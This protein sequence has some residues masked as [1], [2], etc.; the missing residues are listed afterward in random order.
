MSTILAYTS[1][2]IGH[3]YPLTP[4]LLELQR[5]G[6]DVH[7]CTLE[8]RVPLMQSL[9]FTARPIDPRI[10]ALQLK[11]YTASGPRQALAL[12]GDVFATRGKLEAPD[13]TA[14]I[15][16]VRPDTV[17]VDVNSWGA[18]FAAEAWGGPWVSFAP[19][20]PALHSKGTPPFGPGLAP[21][22]G[23]LGSLRDAV[24]GR[25]VLGA[26]ERGMMPRLNQLRG[27]LSLP[28]VTSDEFLR[29]APLMLVA[30]A[31]PFEYATTEWGPDVIMVGASAWEPFQD[32]PAWLGGIVNPIVMVTT[33]SE[34]QD[35]AILVRTALEAFRGR[36]VHVI[37]TMP[38]GVPDDLDVPANATVAEFLPHSAILARAAVAVTHGGMGA[39]QKALI[40]GVPVC[41]VP[42][43]RD[44]LE[45]A[46]RVEVSGSGTRVPRKK[47]APRRLRV[48]VEKAMDMRA[49]AER[50]SR[51]YAATGGS[52]TAADAIERRLLKIPAPAT[53]PAR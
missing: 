33:S 38:A 53:P 37:A 24:V 4:I 20:T 10:E 5:R 14:A 16:E 26:V 25:M 34:F 27:D 42:F 21:M 44:Q 18:G 28:P 15:A 41:V 1:P 17:I 7:V 48:A 29:T 46:R 12:V 8:H 51:G 6:H 11:D 23:P 3:L 9:G 52:S 47:L 40:H 13:L 45:V 49:G 31:K 36:P 43:G 39:T 32:A 50:V 22:K 2:A 30:T 35:D 19:Y